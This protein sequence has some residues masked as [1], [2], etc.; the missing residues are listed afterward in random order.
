[1]NHEDIKDAKVV[2]NQCLGKV[3]LVGAGPGDPGLMTLK[4]RGY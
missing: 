1:M 3:Y 2:S 4:E